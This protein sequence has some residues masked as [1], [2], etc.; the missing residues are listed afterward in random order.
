MGICLS[1]IHIFSLSVPASLHVLFIVLYDTSLITTVLLVTEAQMVRFVSELQ[2]IYCRSQ[3]WS[4]WIINK[5]ES[6][7]L[8]ALVL[9]F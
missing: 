5:K 4:E 2:V 3:I 7:A 1:L 8:G 6:A 9:N